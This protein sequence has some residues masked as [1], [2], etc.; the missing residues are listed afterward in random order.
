MTRV[1]GLFAAL[2]FTLTLSTSAQAQL[3]LNFTGLED[4]GPDAVYEGW[5]IV[6][7]APVST[8]IFNVDSEGVPSQT[9]FGVG[10][11]LDN[12]SAFVLTIEPAVDPDPGP[13]DTHLLGGDIVNGSAD[14]TVGHST[15]LGDDFT[16]AAGSFIL[17]VPS[18]DPGTASHTQGIWWLDPTAAGG[19]APSYSLPTLPAGWVYEGWVVGPGGPVSTGTFLTPAGADSDGGGATAGPNPT[20]PFPGQDFIDPA[21]DLVGYAAVL[22]IEPIVDNSPAPFLLKP[23]VDGE[24]EDVGAGVLQAMMNNAASFPTGT[25]SSVPE[26]S[27][28]GLAMLAFAASG[29]ARRRRNS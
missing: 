23:L 14:L 9:Q 20:P 8:G 29:L 21:T 3:G 25:V 11:A 2:L 17:A 24:S 27:S 10:D 15:A 7:G 18:V 16:S 13:S 4:L 22:S 26:P 19:P 1:S 12:A 6:D 28:L 5:L